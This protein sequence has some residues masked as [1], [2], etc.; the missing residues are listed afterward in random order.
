MKSMFRGAL[1][2]L[3][4]ALTLGAVASA[5]ASAA[6]PTFT[7]PGAM[8]GVESYPI[9]AEVA[10]STVRSEISNPVKQWECEGANGAL[11]VKQRTQA[12]ESTIPFTIEFKHCGG[13][14]TPCE[15][16]GAEAG[17][18][19]L[20]GT[21][22]PVYIPGMQKREKAG[23]LITLTPTYLTCLD[24]KEQIRGSILVPVTP[25]NTSAKELSL[26]FE[27]NGS[28]SP[29][30]TTYENAE[31]SDIEAKLEM[32][33]GAG[34][35]VVALEVGKGL[36]WSVAEGKSLEVEAEV[37][38]AALPRFAPGLFPTAL[39]GSS[40]AAVKISNPVKLLTCEG[41]KSADSITGAKALNVSMEFTKCA[42]SGTKCNTVGA[43]AGVE[44]LS[45]TAGVVYINKAERLAGTILTLSASEIVCGTTKAK[46]RGSV[47]VPVTPTNTKTTQFDLAL[48][49]N[50]EGGPTYT[51][52]ENEKGE[53][54]EAELEVNL[55]TGYRKAALEVAE[56]LKLNAGE[57]L[58][59]EA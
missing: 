53:A 41:V 32:N 4:A 30:Y 20:S 16:E 57:T 51:G 47:L 54:K 36:H 21:A 15:T 33:F 5:S 58:M 24:N 14:L 11:E 37:P 35:K 10:S 40:S 19:L 9:K 39:E 48:T 8:L 25:L 28:G 52:Y 59:L 56:T 50:G 46:V 6:R 44:V 23:V 31:G 22:S 55:G 27:G 12:G 49:G 17:H 29:T 3:A 13:S 38:S 42:T 18:E 7:V 34:Y 1:V 43:G 26:P 45:G 2:A